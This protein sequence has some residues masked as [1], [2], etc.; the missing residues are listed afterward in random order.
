MIKKIAIV[1]LDYHVECLNSLCKIFLD[2]PIEVVFYTKKEIYKELLQDEKFNK[3]TWRFPKKGQSLKEFI[4]ESIPEINLCD[5]VFF[6][7]LASNF[8]QFSK[9]KF[10]PLSFLRIHN[11][12]AYLSPWRNLKFGFTPY[13]IFK[14]LSHIIRETILKLDWYYRKKCVNNFDYLCFPDQAI[15][16]HL[17]QHNML[18]SFRTSSPIPLTINDE[19]FINNEKSD[20]YYFTVPGTI[21]ERRK[22]YLILFNAFRKMLQSLDRKVV[23]TFAGVPKGAYGRNVIS[24]FR[25][26]KSDNFE[27]HFFT[28]RIPQSVFNSVMQKT[29]CIIAPIVSKTKYT[30]YLE[31]YGKTKIS[32]NVS[33]IIQYGK[34]GVLPSSY[35]INKNLETAI[36]QYDSEEQLSVLMSEIVSKR[37]RAKK[38]VFKEY[39]S[40]SV[41]KIILDAFS[42]ELKK[43]L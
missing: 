18:A 30:I 16:D 33:D 9:I 6:D 42:V 40:D 20:V 21:D 22:D 1:E 2:S 13:F 29:D 35:P 10:R 41:Y 7:T 38:E 26:L 19:K 3:Y 4:T 14:D 32:G 36:L 37:R 15:I 5:V 12:N 27:F 11:A 39:S 23:L 8:K 43:S 25:E 17:N 24:K 28:K 31:E 34:L